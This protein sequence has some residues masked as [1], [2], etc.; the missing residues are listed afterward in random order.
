VRIK[1]ALASSM[2]A[3]LTGLLLASG[4]ARASEPPVPIDPSLN[5]DALLRYRF[6]TGE[7]Q[8]YRT[9]IDQRMSMGGAG[10]GQTAETSMRLVLDAL[11]AVTAVDAETGVGTLNQQVNGATVNVT[12][13]GQSLPV[14]ELARQ[15]NGVTMTVR[16]SPRGEVVAVE[17]G[18]AADPQTAQMMS[19]ME[20]SMRR[21]TI[22]FPEEAVSVGATWTREIP[23]EL[24]QPGM[25][26]ETSVAATYTL[27][28]YAHVE[29][30]PC[31]ALQNDITLSLSGTFEEMG[32]T[33]TARGTG[34]GTGY[35]YFDVEAGE[36][37]RSTMDMTLDTTVT[38]E[39]IELTQ[40]IAMALN[41]TRLSG[42]AP[43]E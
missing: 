22:E 17:M 23:L 26:M 42:E 6:T 18:E 30:R 31:A 43:V 41:V 25:E 7:T 20:E 5:G 12:I 35:T 3:A 29:G 1:I 32:L 15:L 38:A 13:N 14:E 21:T 10:L 28:G 9:E 40:S 34:A 2:L 4:P 24:E 19:L 11:H 8:V 39:G 36:L 37:V 33:S 16:M 27:L